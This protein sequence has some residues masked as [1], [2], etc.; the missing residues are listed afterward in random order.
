VAEKIVAEKIVAEKI[1]AEKI[2]ARRQSKEAKNI[3]SV[4]RLS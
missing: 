2:V 1:V 3:S 4:F